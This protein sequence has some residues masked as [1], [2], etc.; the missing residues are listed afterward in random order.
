MGLFNL[1]ILLLL[2]LSLMFDCVVGWPHEPLVF[3]LLMFA[4]DGLALTCYTGW[5]RVAPYGLVALV[6]LIASSDGH[7]KLKLSLFLLLSMLCRMASQSTT[8]INVTP[9]DGLA[10]LVFVSC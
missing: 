2:L 9:P 4:P 7:T 6:A 8:L 5:P 1:L 10:E 3:F